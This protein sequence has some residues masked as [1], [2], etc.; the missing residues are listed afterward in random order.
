MA[1]P[2]GSWRADLIGL[3]SLRL[4]A[5]QLHKERRSTELSTIIFSALSHPEAMADA[6]GHPTVVVL[7]AS[8]RAELPRVPGSLAI[9]LV[10]LFVSLSTTRLL[11]S[12]LLHLAV[13][14]KLRTLDFDLG[15]PLGGAWPI[16]SWSFQVS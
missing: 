11:F 6:V 12:D 15:D 1:L 10:S 14:G 7:I 4:G 5:S 3:S 2:L 13:N 16:S 8:S 9:E